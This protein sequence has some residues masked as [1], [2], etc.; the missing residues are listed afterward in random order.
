MPQPNPL[1]PVELLRE[2]FDYNPETGELTFLVYNNRHR[3]GDVLTR[4][5][6]HGYLC[7]TFERKQYY[8]H[9]IAWKIQTGKEPPEVVDHRNRKPDD[10][11]WQ[12]LRA[13]DNTS[14]RY[15]MTPWGKRFLPGVSQGRPGGNYYAKI[16]ANKRQ[17]YLGT[18]RTEEEAH[19]AYCDA[20]R[21]H[22]GE[23][24]IYAD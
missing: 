11:R 9:R 21:Q 14:N 12:N 23:H 24:S 19:A 4:R 7:W 17:I 2:I 8:A 22:F 1:P 6:A 20:H 10:N 18:F 15:N 13:S 3:K 5:T 16:T